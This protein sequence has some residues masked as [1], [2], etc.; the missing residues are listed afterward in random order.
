MVL[1]ASDDWM[2][3]L[4]YFSLVFLVLY[5]WRARDPERVKMESFKNFLRNIVR[6][7]SVTSF[8]YV[9]LCHLLPLMNIYEIDRATVIFFHTGTW[10]VHWCIF[11][12]Q[13]NGYKYSNQNNIR[14]LYTGQIQLSSSYMSSSA[15]FLSY[16]GLSRALS[17]I[18]F[19]TSESCS[20]SWV[21]FKRLRTV[22]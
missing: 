6:M 16:M 2:L 12:A 21:R 13:E 14:I 15:G 19:R 20:L 1:Y 18:R 22:H 3:Y 11:S 8:L 5:H 10:D 9:A 17:W 4:V 7:N